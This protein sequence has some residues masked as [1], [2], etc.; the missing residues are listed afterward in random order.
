MV[1]GLFC[2]VGRGAVGRGAVGR[3]AVGRGSARAALPEP[4]PTRS[5]VLFTR[6]ADA[7]SNEQTVYDETPTE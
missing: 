4:R 2:S 5:F 6:S 3:G 1:L 7:L